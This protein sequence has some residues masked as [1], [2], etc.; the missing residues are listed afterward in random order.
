MND[1]GVVMKLG[2][3]GSRTFYCGRKWGMVAIPG[4]GRRCGPT[5]GLQ[6]R[7]CKSAQ[8]RILKAPA[9]NLFTQMHLYMVKRAI[10]WQIEMVVLKA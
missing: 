1:A 7:D 5:A 4:S 3:A 8:E 2:R 9:P 6:C 10:N